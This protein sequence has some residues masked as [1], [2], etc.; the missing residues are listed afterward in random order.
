MSL[1]GGVSPPF[2]ELSFESFNPGQQSGVFFFQNT[3]KVFPRVADKYFK[4]KK[5]LKEASMQYIIDKSNWTQSATKPRLW[6]GET[7]ESLRFAG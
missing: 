5:A 4:S 7:L 6:N 1:M 3:S 2:H